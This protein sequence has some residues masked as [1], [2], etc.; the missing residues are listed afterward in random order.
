[1]ATDS[2]IDLNLI[3][4]DLATFKTWLSNNNTIVY[5]ILST[6]TT[7]EITNT[8]LIEQLETLYN[9]KSKNGTTNITITSQDLAMIMGVNVIKGDA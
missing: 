1:M 6:P 2:W 8:E 3:A 9:A 5:Y 4:S 7:T